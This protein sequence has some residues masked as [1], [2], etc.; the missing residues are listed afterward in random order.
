MSAK[1]FKHDPSC[2][3]PA[4]MAKSSE[5]R[6]YGVMCN[7]RERRSGLDAFAEKV[8]NMEFVNKAELAALRLVADYA[9]VVHTDQIR[10]G[11]TNFPGVRELGDAIGALNCILG[12]E[13]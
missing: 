10:A 6:R 9:L 7:C 5:N 1:A 13:K 11:R 3:L 8:R 2:P 4:E 12:T